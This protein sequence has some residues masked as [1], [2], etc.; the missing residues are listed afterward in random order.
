MR[1]KYFLKPLYV[2]KLIYS[3]GIFLTNY[4]HYFLTKQKLFIVKQ[5][6]IYHYL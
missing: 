6:L 1:E 2:R 3:L 5:N 4:L